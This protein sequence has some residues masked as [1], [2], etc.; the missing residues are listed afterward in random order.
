[1]REMVIKQAAAEDL[2]IVAWLEKT[3]RKA[4]END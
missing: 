3:L 4:T 1:L 2:S